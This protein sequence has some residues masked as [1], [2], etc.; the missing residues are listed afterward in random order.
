[1]RIRIL[2]S[3]LLCLALGAA[4]PAGR[5]S[6]L[7]MLAA[8][9]KQADPSFAGFSADRGRAFWTSTHSGGNPDTR[10]CTACHT[11]DPRAIGQTR[12]GKSIEPMAVSQNPQRFTDAAKVEQWFRRNCNTVLGSDC[13]PTEKGD[14][15][16]YLTSQ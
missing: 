16:T 9:A 14:V 4:A 2:A 13:T 12:A 15:I 3:A 7:A 5:D 10:S 8:Q 6:V 11:P 1:M